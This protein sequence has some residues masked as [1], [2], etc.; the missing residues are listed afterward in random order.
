[1][2]AAVG[3]GH[4]E[5]LGD[6]FACLQRLNLGLSVICAV[7]PVTGG[8]DAEAAERAVD[9]TGDETG[10]TDIRVGDSERTGGG[11]LTIR[12]ILVFGQGGLVDAADERQIVEIDDD[13]AKGI[14]DRAAA[15]VGADPDIDG[16]LSASVAL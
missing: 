6:R 15:V 12:D 13:Q 4:G 2:G 9:R 11:D 14:A 7:T 16:L 3:G 8:V 10:L 5:R 1:V